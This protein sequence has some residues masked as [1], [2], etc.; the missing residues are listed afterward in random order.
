MKYLAD[1]HVLLWWMADPEQLSEAVTETLLR[2]AGE[3]AFSAV[4]GWEIAV[5][6]SIGSKRRCPRR[7]GENSPSHCVTFPRRLH[8]RFTTTIRSIARWWLKR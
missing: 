7:V 5:K 3:V 6:M 2:R 1:T 4:S 8:C